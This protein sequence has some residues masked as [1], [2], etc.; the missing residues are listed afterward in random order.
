MKLKKIV[1]PVKLWKRVAAYFIDVI[2]VNLIIVY[3]FKDFFGNFEEDLFFKEFSSEILMAFLIISLLTIL[4]W[5]VLEYF[6][7]QSVGKSLMNIYVRSTEN[8]L[9][10]WPCVLRNLSKV[11]TL[12]LL[13]D[14]LG[15]IFKKDYQRFLERLSKTEV[16]DG[17]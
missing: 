4:Y 7:K 6:L 9:N 3:P 11:S 12:L 14:S 13:I 1:A 2:I 5:A 17:E 16:V 15:I 10:F 8:E